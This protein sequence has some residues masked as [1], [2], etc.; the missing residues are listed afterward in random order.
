MNENFLTNNSRT[1]DILSV[2]KW[3]WHVGEAISF[4]SEIG[5]LAI[6]CGLW[7]V[8]WLILK[9]GENEEERWRRF[10]RKDFRIF[11]NFIRRL[12][13]GDEKFWN[14]DDWNKQLN[15]IAVESLNWWF[16]IIWALIV[17]ACHCLAQ[18]SWHASTSFGSDYPWSTCP[19]S[20][21]ESNFSVL[22]DAILK[23]RRIF[24]VG[25]WK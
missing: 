8:D 2:I 13:S 23:R 25:F 1:H 17:F 5:W 18:S 24:V 6:F 16:W 14:I 7:I 11:L 4:G 3:S 22:A 15:F 21:F 12:T 20:R 10:C 9:F 19:R